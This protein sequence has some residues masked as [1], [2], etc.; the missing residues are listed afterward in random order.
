MT[1]RDAKDYATA[2]RPKTPT[3][4][5]DRATI[6]EATINTHTGEVIGERPTVTTYKGHH[7]SKQQIRTLKNVDAHLSGAISAL[8]AVFGGGFEK[9]CTPEIAA[10]YAKSYKAYAKRLVRFARH[11]EVFGAA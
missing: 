7:N 2:P 8:D 9:S 4:Q 5:P 1:I 3:P 11:L 6:G 10:G